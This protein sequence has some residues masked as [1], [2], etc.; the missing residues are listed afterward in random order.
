MPRDLHIMYWLVAGVDNVDSNIYNGRLI[1]FWPDLLLY[2]HSA[3]LFPAQSDHDL[4]EILLNTAESASKLSEI[5]L[6][7]PRDNRGG[8]TAP[9][10]RQEVFSDENLLGVPDR[11]PRAAVLVCQ[12]LEAGK[13]MVARPLADADL[14]AHV[15]GDLQVQGGAR[16]DLQPFTP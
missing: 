2:V 12:D 13:L 3:G 1:P 9:D 4:V 5:W 14:S 7:R 16:T 11:A 10:R 6:R 8:H 15:F